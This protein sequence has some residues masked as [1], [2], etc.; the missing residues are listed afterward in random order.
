MAMKNQEVHDALETYIKTFDIK[1]FPG[2]NV[3]TA[4]LCLKAV[5]QTLR[6]KCLPTNTICKILNSLSAKFVLAGEKLVAT[7]SI[8]M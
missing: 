7:Y 1:V 8:S 4:C 3:P 5:A 6:N 2:E